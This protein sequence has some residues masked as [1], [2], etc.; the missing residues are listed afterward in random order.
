MSFTQALG[1]TFPLFSLILLGFGLVRWLHWP[2][3]IGDALGRFVFTV[4]LP[5]LLLNLTS[6]LASLPPLDPRV[7]LERSDARSLRPGQTLTLYLD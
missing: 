6:Q 5:A 3:S 1:T 7:L 2:Q 4:A